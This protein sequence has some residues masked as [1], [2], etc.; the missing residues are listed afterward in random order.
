MDCKTIERNN[1]AI[2]GAQSP[3]WV[4]WALGRGVATSLEMGFIDKSIQY[5]WDVCGISGI[6]RDFVGNFPIL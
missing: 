6:C 5:P 4:S 2:I 1:S 3:S